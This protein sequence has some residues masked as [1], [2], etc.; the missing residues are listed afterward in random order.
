MEEYILVIAVS[1]LASCFTFFSGFGL[2]TLLTPVFLLFFPVSIA[3]GMTGIVHFCNNIFKLTLIGKYADKE[4]V[5]K[6]GIPSIIGAILGAFLLLK[7]TNIAPLYS[8]DFFHLHANISLLKIIIG[9]AIIIFTIIDLLPTQFDFTNKP[10]SFTIGGFLSGFFGGLS[11]NQGALRSM[12]LIKTLNQKEVYIATGIVIAC[13][14]DVTR[15]GLYSKFFINNTW[16][17]RTI[18]MLICAIIAALSGAILGN[19]LLHKIK[20]KFVQNIVT[21]GLI[22]IAI[23]LIS[24]II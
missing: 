5:I 24:G 6:F 20:L 21:I 22:L 17:P 23:G 15:I 18:N 3:I 19:K 7:L 8:Y 9:I 12:F 10:Y 13:L 16:E 14:V 4:V 2:G 1:F 11:G